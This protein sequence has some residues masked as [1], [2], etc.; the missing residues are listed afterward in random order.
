M[1]YTYE[2]DLSQTEQVRASQVVF[3]RRWSTRFSYVGL[4]LVMLLVGI[5]GLS[6]TDGRAW[7]VILPTVI[8]GIAGGVGAIYMSPYWAVR[9]LRRKNRAAASRHV[10]QLESTGITATALGATGTISWLNVVEA[11]ETREFLLFYV[12]IAWAWLLPKRVVPDGEL[13]NLRSSL[14]SWLGERAHV[15]EG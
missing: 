11:Y 13:A 10:Y 5:W 9:G 12:S 1:T 7:P 6:A 3:N 2:F 4:I 14:R 8:G 15:S